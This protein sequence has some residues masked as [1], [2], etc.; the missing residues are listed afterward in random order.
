MNQVTIFDFVVDPLYEELNQIDLDKSRSFVF[1]KVD[2][3]VKKKQIGLRELFEFEYQDGHGLAKS[4]HE[5]IEKI[6]EIETTCG[7]HHD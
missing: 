1:N 2:F 7:V 3:K 4:I 5:L 6:E